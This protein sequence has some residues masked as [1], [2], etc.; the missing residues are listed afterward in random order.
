[1]GT[2]LPPRKGAQQRSPHFS[3]HFALARSPISATAA[4]SCL[5]KETR[6]LR[7]RIRSLVDEFSEK[8]WYCGVFSGRELRRGR[9]D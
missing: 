2:Q 9:K 3:A 6:F 8:D 5:F 1:M 4:S 7:I